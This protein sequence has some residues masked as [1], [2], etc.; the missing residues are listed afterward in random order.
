[1]ILK[2][3]CINSNELSQIDILAIKVI[4]ISLLFQINKIF[5]GKIH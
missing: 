2:A 1:M 3:N 5:T 4:I